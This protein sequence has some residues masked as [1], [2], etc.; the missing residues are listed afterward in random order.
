MSSDLQ[1]VRTTLSEVQEKAVAE[2]LVAE[3]IAAMRE[4]RSGHANI[5]FLLAARISG[6]RY[7]SD[8][9]LVME[10]REGTVE[11]TRTVK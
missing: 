9:G 1:H 2:W 6:G 7:E 11:L 10:I 8:D 5:C 4:G 3:G